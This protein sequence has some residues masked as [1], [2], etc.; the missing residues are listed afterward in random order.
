[1]TYLLD[2]CIISKL[3]KIKSRSDPKLESWI[4]KHSET[5]LYLSVITIGEIQS[6]IAKLDGKQPEEKRKRRILED[7]LFA[8]LI[9]RFQERILEI[10][11]AV[12]LTWGKIMGISRRNGN[13][14]P[15]I[16]ALLAATA[17]TYQLIVVTEN[18]RDFE[19]SGAPCF[20][21]YE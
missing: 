14:L 21:P 6:G 9:P 1:M 16:D 4:E 7:W 13:Q 10:D 12:A 20:N 11:S 2:T 18:V 17:L 19:N 3:R 8:S 5:Q 15:A